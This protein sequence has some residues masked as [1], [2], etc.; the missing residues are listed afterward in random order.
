MRRWLCSC[1]PGCGVLGCS[2][3]SLSPLL[4]PPLS[5][6]VV[7]VGGVSFL[8]CVLSRFVVVLERYGYEEGD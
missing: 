3:L 1:G 2:P 6:L 7:C 4:P 5:L 8:L